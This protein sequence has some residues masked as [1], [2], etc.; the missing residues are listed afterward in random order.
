MKVLAT[1]FCLFLIFAKPASA[2]EALVAVAA[3]F[4]SV[5]EELAAAFE[6]K[7][8]H[9]VLVASGSTGSLYAQILNGAPYDALLAADQERPRLLEESGFAVA[10][11]RQTYATGRLVLWSADSELILDDLAAT[12]GQ[13][14]IVSVAIA[15]PELAPYGAASREALNSLQVWESIRN[16]IV[17]GENIGQTYALVAT[18]NAQLGLVALSQAMNSDKSG[19]PA[20]LPVAENL[21][22]PIRQDAVLLQHGHDNAAAR[23]FLLFLRSAEGKTIVSNHG[24]GVN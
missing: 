23:E 14:H 20:Y 10:D 16:R 15:N 3:N 2:E 18:Q 17:M 12:I 11:S 13:K 22:A 8:G 5:M 6:L 7:S 21:H 4:S 9:E 1:I 19:K 24:Y